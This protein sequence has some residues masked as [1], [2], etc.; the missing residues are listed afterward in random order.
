MVAAI[1][2]NVQK[3]KRHKPSAIA[4]IKKD[5]VQKSKRHKLKATVVAAI[6]DEYDQ[7]PMDLKPTMVTAVQKE[8]DQ[9]PRLRKTGSEPVKKVKAKPIKSSS[10]KNALNKRQRRL[11]KLHSKKHADLVVELLPLW[12]V[13]RR[14]DTPEAK[15]FEIID[16]IIKKAQDKLYDLCYAHDTARIVECAVK[17]GTEAQRWILFSHL[18][19][20]LRIL[21][22]SRY[23]KFILIKLLKY[24]AK[25]HQLEMFKV[26][27]GHVARLVKNRV[28][29]ELVDMLFTDYANATQRGELMQELYGNVHALQLSEHRVHSL[30]DACALNP[31]KSKIILYNVT[32][33]L[34]SLVQKGLA[35][36]SIVQHLLLEYLHTIPIDAPEPAHSKADPMEVDDVSGK[37][38]NVDGDG[39]FTTLLELLTENQ[40]VPM[41]HTRV[42]VRAALR[43]LWIS[44]PRLRKVFVRGLKTCISSIA[45]NEHGHLLL[46]GLLD[47]VDDIEL[48][49]KLVIKEILQDL[50]LFCSHPEAR[51]VLLYALSPRDTRHFSPQLQQSMYHAGDANPYT[52]KPLGVRALELRSPSVGLLPHLLKLAAEHLMDLFVGDSSLDGQLALEDRGRLVLLAE[53]LIRSAPHHLDADNVVN[54]Y[55]RSGNRTTADLSCIPLAFSEQDKEGLERLRHDA[56]RQVVERL[57]VP[58][59]VPLIN[60]ATSHGGSHHSRDEERIK[61]HKRAVTLVT[62]AYSRSLKPAFSSFT[63]ADSDED[64]ADEKLNTFRLSTEPMPF[65]ERPEG[66]LFLRR[67]LQDSKL[68]HD[69]TLPHLLMELVTPSNLCAWTRCNRSCFVLVSLYELGDPPTCELLRSSLAPC[70]EELAVSPLPSAKVLWKHLNVQE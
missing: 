14:E 3:L 39:D 18:K 26:F 43:V 35:K 49:R 6:N 62:E 56:L 61:R 53:I 23:A 66:H 64:Q 58:D 46:I 4:A 8:H 44:P 13:L 32:N 12:E 7:R 65:L 69:L 63:F 27:R 42:G 33:L 30:K 45:C 52:K 34:I 70:F 54:S 22:T 41:L 59:F 16:A 28:A 17:H 48:L 2:R 1:K 24:G 67:L 9:K 25:E 15:R 40:I 21:A 29:C 38:N 57:L 55:N 51:K 60:S 19:K 5:G 68:H 37:L 31:Q 50:K 47:S 36:Y 10:T 11:L 20:H